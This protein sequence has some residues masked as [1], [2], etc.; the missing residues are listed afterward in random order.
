MMPLPRVSKTFSSGINMIDEKRMVI[1]KISTT[2]VDRDGDVMMPSGIDLTHFRENPV[3]LFGHDSSRMP[4]GKAMRISTEP[5]SVIAEVKF[6][7]RPP[8]HPDAAEWVPDTMLSMF[9][10]NIL[11]AFSVGFIIPE[12]G[13]RLANK[14]DQTRFPGVKRVINKWQ[15]LEFSVVPIPSN[16]GALATAVSKGLL[17]DESWAFNQLDF[18]DDEV[19]QEMNELQER[20][21]RLRV[22][23][24]TVKMIR[25]D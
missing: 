5:N 7:E 4:V 8:E 15:L 13:A 18:D 16:P 25:I 12:G 9:K 14:K 19:H 21:Y 20:H 10:Q 23:V 11:R 3:V 17:S 1:A 24:H 2:D 22:P 6:A